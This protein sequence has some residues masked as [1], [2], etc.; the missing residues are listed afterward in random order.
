M[1][2]FIYIIYIYIYTRTNI[3]IQTYMKWTRNVQ[4]T[5]AVRAKKG[6][7]ILCMYILLCVYIIV[8]CIHTYGSSCVYI[9][10]HVHTSLNRH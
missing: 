4:R 8:Y 1:Y 9:C 7:R 6:T 10:I 3:F 2:I 5:I